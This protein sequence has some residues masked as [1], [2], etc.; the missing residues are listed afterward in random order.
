MYCL[1]L[2]H[3]TDCSCIRVLAPFFFLVKLS[4]YPLLD[5]EAAAKCCK[6][7]QAAFSTQGLEKTE[8]FWQSA[9]LAL[10]PMG[11]LK[12]IRNKLPFCPFLSRRWKEV[13]PG[14]PCCCPW[15]WSAAWQVSAAGSTGLDPLFCV[16][17]G[18]PVPGYRGE[19]THCSFANSSDLIFFQEHVIFFLHWIVYFVCYRNIFAQQKL[20]SHLDSFYIWGCR[21]ANLAI[22][23]EELLMCS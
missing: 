10:S 22:L 23:H 18:A 21:K 5:P 2:I 20:V 11:I 9:E 3:M 12:R 17:R 8:Q 7:Q 19:E 15:G 6:Q 13:L 4:C 16:L 1:K 14:I